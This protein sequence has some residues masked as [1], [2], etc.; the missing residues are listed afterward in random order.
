MTDSDRDR[1][2]RRRL[3]SVLSLADRITAHA[4]FDH[5]DPVSCVAL[6]CLAREVRLGTLLADAR[7]VN[8]TD[9]MPTMRA[10]METWVDLRWICCRNSHR[11][12]N[13]FIKFQPVAQTRILEELGASPEELRIVRRRRRQPRHLFFNPETRRWA[14]SWASKPLRQRAEEIRE[15]D[16]VESSH[17]YAYYRQF[18]AAAHT[19]VTT[20]GT[21]ERRRGGSIV[22]VPPKIWRTWVLLNYAAHILTDT[23][24]LAN[25]RTNS[26]YAREIERALAANRRFEQRLRA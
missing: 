14:S 16:R 20:L 4:R 26:P 24:A 7:P 8:P 5:T 11:R 25:E 17:L 21:L 2:T 1:L 6:G 3:R 18:S 22:V 9:L 19:D 12:A 23:C 13:R 15:A 10:M